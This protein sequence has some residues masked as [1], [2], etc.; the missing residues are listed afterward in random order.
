MA[1][2][3]AAGPGGAVSEEDAKLITLARAA[4]A[5]TG[6]R[7][8]AAVRDTTGRTYAA[9]TVALPS[10]ALTAL[11]AAV[12]AAIASGAAGIEAA[13]VAGPAP[14]G[15]GPDPGVDAVR[16]LSGPGVAV[17]R[18]SSSGELAATHRS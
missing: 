14:E 1:E 5:R 2:P 10:L 9:C 3:G 4:R 11:Q 16:D 7:E 13:A 17:H 12:A 6:A 18:A 15:A 8:G